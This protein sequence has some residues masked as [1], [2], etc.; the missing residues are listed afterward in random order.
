[1]L[2]IDEGGQLC[3]SRH[4]AVG[5][6][7]DVT[8][9]ETDDGLYV[10]REVGEVG[11]TLGII[12]EIIVGLLEGTIVGLDGLM[13]GD[14]VNIAEGDRVGSRLGLLELG[15]TDGAQVGTRLGVAVGSVGT[16]LDMGVGLLVAALLGTIEVTKEG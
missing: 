8:D 11:F 15:M 7:V 2:G 16:M 6:S 3:S 1:M 14:I 9:G 5:T 10:G 13:L 12:L 4:N